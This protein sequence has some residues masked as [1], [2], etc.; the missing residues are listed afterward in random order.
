MLSTSIAHRAQSTSHVRWRSC[1]RH[2]PALPGT[3]RA[4][5]DEGPAVVLAVSV[6]RAGVSGCPTRRFHVWGFC[7][8]PSTS[9]R[10]AAPSRAQAPGNA[11]LPN[12]AFVLSRG[13]APHNSPTCHPEEP[14]ATRDLLFP[15]PFPQHLT[16]QRTAPAIAATSNPRSFRDLSVPFFLLRR[17]P[18]SASSRPKWRPDFSRIPFPLSESPRQGELSR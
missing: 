18:L 14:Q 11:I 12:G 5:G 16:P 9:S 1:F 4:S 2:H 17:A 3:R 13:C 7:Q 8:P 6:A 10:P 15:P